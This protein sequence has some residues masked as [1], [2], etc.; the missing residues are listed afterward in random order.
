MKQRGRK[1]ES[2]ESRKMGES[3]ERQ[4]TPRLD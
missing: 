3:N 2:S 4:K 1:I